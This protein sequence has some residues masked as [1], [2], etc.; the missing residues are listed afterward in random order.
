MLFWCS[1]MC[2]IL[3]QAV[4]YHIVSLQK[5]TPRDTRI[6][7]GATMGNLRSLQLRMEIDK[8]S[9][10]SIEHASQIA[11]S[12][13][14]TCCRFCIPQLS[15]LYWCQTIQK[16]PWARRRDS[17][18]FQRRFCAVG[19][20]LYSTVVLCM[21]HVELPKN[22]FLL[23][24]DALAGRSLGFSRVS[25]VRSL[26]MD[27]RFVVERWKSSTISRGDSCFFQVARIL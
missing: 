6:R 8:H 3:V 5:P 24:S 14:G 15:T 20:L 10:Q 21:Q 7:C 27:G 22:G 13:Y 1:Q 17:G 25:R 16:A 9:C 11:L 4:H 12:S 26:E 18:W 19:P 2:S 23:V